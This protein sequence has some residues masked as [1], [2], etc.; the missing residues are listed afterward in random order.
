M[1]IAGCSSADGEGDL[2][3]SPD[4]DE[5]HATLAKDQKSNSDAGEDQSMNSDTDEDQWSSSD[6]GEDQSTISSN[7]EDQ[8]SSSETLEDQGLP[9]YSDSE[10]SAVSVSFSPM[11]SDELVL[12]VLDDIQID[13]IV[14]EYQVEE[15]TFVIF[16]K[17]GQ[18][19]QY[20]AGFSHGT[21]IYQF[22]DMGYAREHLLIEPVE[23]FGQSIVKM[24]GI[25]GAACPINLYV[26][27][28]E[29]LPQLMLAS[30]WHTH[31]ID[32][33]QD[34][35]N[36]I[37]M[38]IGTEPDSKIVIYEDE[39]LLES[40]S[41]SDTIH[42]VTSIFYSLDKEAFWASDVNQEWRYYTYLNKEL[43]PMNK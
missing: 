36:E 8:S 3:S 7:G 30:N 34:G 17:S 37:V 14:A 26:Y 27:I 19:H 23:V 6:A 1:L 29:K 33:D 43:V 28:E 40:D 35:N 32:L 24:V 5:D 11:S 22:W 9:S 25:C 16:S 38:S 15:G 4:A 13:E 41:L 31:E 12:E 20:F 42:D 10:Q 18:S 39:Q 2:S 21:S